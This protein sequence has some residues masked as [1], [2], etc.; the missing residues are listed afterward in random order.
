MKRLEHSLRY[1]VPWWRTHY[2]KKREN[3]IILRR[4]SLNVSV[5]TRARPQTHTTRRAVAAHVVSDRRHRCVRVD[6][7]VRVCAVSYARTE[8]MC[9]VR[10]QGTHGYKGSVAYKTRNPDP[11]TCPNTVR[12]KVGCNIRNVL[13]GP[14]QFRNELVQISGEI[15]K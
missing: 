1:R 15:S 9:A 7:P 2:E 6:D 4:K 3:F 5:R 10:I 14:F 11:G 8:P 13:K 12:R